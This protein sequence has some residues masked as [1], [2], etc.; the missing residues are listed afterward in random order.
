MRDLGELVAKGCGE[1]KAGRQPLGLFSGYLSEFDGARAQTGRRE[2]AL[3]VRPLG[4]GDW[5]EAQAFIENCAPSWL[6]SL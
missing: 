3:E 5:G 4:E 2:D 6:L 1:I